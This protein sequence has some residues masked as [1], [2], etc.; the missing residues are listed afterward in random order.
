MPE[1]WQSLKS[2]E[3]IERDWVTDSRPKVYIEIL[4]FL[5]FELRTI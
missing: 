5:S 2:D 3:V 1:D 4:D